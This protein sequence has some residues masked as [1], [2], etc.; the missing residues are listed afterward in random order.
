MGYEPYRFIE[1]YSMKDLPGWVYATVSVAA[2]GMLILMCVT[3]YEVKDCAIKYNCIDE[4]PLLKLFCLAFLSAFEFAFFVFC[5]IVGIYD[6]RGRI[7]FFFSNN[8]ST[9]KFRNNG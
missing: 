4:L 6:F 1:Y 2:A 9:Y 5:F 8:K 7:F 3:M